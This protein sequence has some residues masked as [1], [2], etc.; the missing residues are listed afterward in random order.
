MY[1]HI[2]TDIIS[3]IVISAIYFCNRSIT[4]QDEIP[5]R[6]RRFSNC[7][8][9]GI[10]VTLIDIAASIVMEIPTPHFLYHLM[11]TLY[12]LSIEF[13]IVIWF[14]YVLTIIYPNEEKNAKTIYK[15][16]LIIYACYAL[17]ICSNLWNGLVYS[18]TSN[19]EYSRGPLFN[20]VVLAYIFYITALFILILLRRNHIPK[21]YPSWV[22]TAT[23]IIIAIGIAVQL[24]VPGWL[25]TMPAYMFCLLMAFMFFQT[26]LV[27]KN[28]EQFDNLSKAA[29]TD[30]LT[31]LFNR[32][33]MEM[34]VQKTL[35]E[36]FG[37]GVV[38]LLADIDDLKIIN[39]TMGHAE[40]D[41]S[42]Q[43]TAAQ[44]KRHF[45]ASD[46]VVRYGGDEFLVFL[47]GAL[48][49]E[50][51]C[52]SL[53][54][55][56]NE[57]RELR[58]GRDNNVPMHGSIGAAYGEVGIDSFES[59]CAKADEALYYVKRH[60]KDGYALYSPNMGDPPPALNK[61]IRT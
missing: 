11:M 8:E 17:F 61:K 12:F 18:L 19:N 4:Q 2:D 59:L 36:S 34:M 24:A 35:S 15:A 52:S 5:M 29:E 27:K 41:R 7:L 60:G 22:L 14:F 49:E 51:I 6:N 13:V 10:I 42:I 39:D 45:R 38:V 54:S 48:K 57:L 9:I 46:T 30:K 1:W 53:Q 28:R 3:L 40:G 21:T 43:M 58:I 23:P 31:G 33:G 26:S 44:L 16:V 56:V 47:T 55:L 37:E 32:S 50:Q 20:V 25:F